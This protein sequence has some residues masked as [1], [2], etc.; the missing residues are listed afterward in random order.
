MT[1][2]KKKTRVWAIPWPRPPH[3]AVFTIALVIGIAGALV[4]GC[5]ALYRYVETMNQPL[6]MK[7]GVCRE[8]T[9]TEYYESTEEGRLCQRKGITYLCINNVR[10][11]RCEIQR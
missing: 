4:H 8:Q 1:E 5:G 9:L 7:E 11:W 3:P 10:S 2:E 6:P